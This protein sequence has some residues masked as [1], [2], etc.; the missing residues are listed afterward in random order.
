MLI[1]HTLPWSV[2]TMSPYISERII[3]LHFGKHHQGYVDKYNKMI[4]EQ[5]NADL[6]KLNLLEVLQKVAFELK[7]GNN[8][9]IALFRNGAQAW[10]HD[11]L[12]KSM[13]PSTDPSQFMQLLKMDFSKFR[14]IFI[15]YATN[16]FASGWIW[17]VQNGNDID[18]CTT[19]NEESPLF[20]VTP[21]QTILN[22]VDIS[23]TTPLAVCDL[24]E[25]AY[26]LDYENNRKHYLEK[27]FDHLMN[28]DFVVKNFKQEA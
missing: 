27:F 16:H 23:T 5:Q 3:N 2:S 12:W 9:R 26:Y 28:W 1:K 25:H 15:D 11:F 20:L 21:G 19:K 18:L 6:H 14:E 10:N 24:W 7:S 13:F 4:N 17:I 22:P 8:N